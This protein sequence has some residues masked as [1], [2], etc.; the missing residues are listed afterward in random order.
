MLNLGLIRSISIG[1]LGLGL[2][3]AFYGFM[4]SDSFGADLA[5]FFTGRPTDQAI[6]LVV[7]GVAMLALGVVALAAS[8]ARLRAMRR[9]A[10]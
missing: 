1:A 7:G 10:G 4:A 5:G 2:G 9:I 8:S 6:W 3:L